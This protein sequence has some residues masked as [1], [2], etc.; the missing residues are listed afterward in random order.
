MAHGYLRVVASPVT[1]ATQK[2][3]QVR[4]CCCR[5]VHACSV[6][7]YAVGAGIT[8]LLQRAPLGGWDVRTCVKVA[9]AFCQE[10][11]GSLS[12]MRRVVWEAKLRDASSW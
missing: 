6:G 5:C 4:A 2:M 3:L 1:V 9:E 12:I 10:T 8:R 7:K 11:R